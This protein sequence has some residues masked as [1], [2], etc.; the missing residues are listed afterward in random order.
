M[1]ISAFNLHLKSNSVEGSEYPEGLYSSVIGKSP[2]T[3][4]LTSNLLR[5]TTL[6]L[7]KAMAKG[8]LLP[9][10]YKLAVVGPY[11]SEARFQKLLAA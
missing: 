10:A 4:V 1:D 8:C 11:R 7:L 2:I 5:L 3:L 6:S 9:N